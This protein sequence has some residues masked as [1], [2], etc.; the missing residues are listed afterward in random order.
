MTS[1]CGGQRKGPSAQTSRKERERC[2]ISER[3]CA[4]KMAALTPPPWR[5][6]RRGREREGSAG[7]FEVEIEAGI[8]VVAVVG[9][10]WESRVK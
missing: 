9:W 10:E 2:F 4:A 7:G 3:D 1:E 8:V 5:Q 6:R